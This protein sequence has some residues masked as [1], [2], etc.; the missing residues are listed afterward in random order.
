MATLYAGTSG[1]AY[2]AWKPDFYPAKLPAAKFLGHYATRLNSVEVN[3][4]FR[5]F[6]TAKMQENWVAATPPEFRFTIKAHQTITHVKRLREAAEFTRSF[7]GSLQPMVESGRLGGV[8]F[9]LPPFLKRD[10]ALLGEFLKTLPLAVRATF[11]FRHPSWFADEVLDLLRD[12]GAA[13]C[14]AE[15][16]KLTAPDIATA[17]FAYYRMRKSDYSPEERKALRTKVAEHI[18][19]GRDVFVYFKHE[20]TPEGAL[21]GEELLKP[22]SP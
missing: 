9:Q 15:S 5:R 22:A 8:L 11:E 3:V 13:L 6:A 1:W 12:A 16:E 14:A 21:Y 2:P 7:L 18:A 17:G 4:T 10:D 20:D 19:A